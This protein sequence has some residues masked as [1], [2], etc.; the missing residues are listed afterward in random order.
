MEGDPK[1]EKPAPP[2]A[3][4]R[5]IPKPTPASEVAGSGKTVL[6]TIPKRVIV[7]HNSR[8]IEF[9]EGAQQVPVE[10]ADHWYLLANG[11]RRVELPTEESEELTDEEKAENEA[12]DR[13][14]EDAEA[15]SEERSAARRKPN[16][17]R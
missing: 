11:A 13:E 5:G 10:F 2:M 1:A 17:K 12:E 9:K 8:L 15:A 7:N 6:M 3:A 16:K 4:G 14:E